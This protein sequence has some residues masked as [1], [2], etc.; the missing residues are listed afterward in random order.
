MPTDKEKEKRKKRAV[1]FAESPWIDKASGKRDD[2]FIQEAENLKHFYSKNQPDYDFEIVPFYGDINE[3]KSKLT[4]V[5]D[6]D[7]IYV[8]GHGAD[9]L[10]NIPNQ[11]IADVFKQQGV[12]N[13]SFGSCSFG[14]YIDP[15][16]DIQNVKYRD[17]DK[18]YGVWPN[19]KDV[20]SAMFA[21]GLDKEKSEPNFPVIGVS[22]PV[23]G[24]HFNRI[25]NRPK[26]EAIPVPPRP[27]P[28]FFK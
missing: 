17:E 28:A 19:A 7:Q 10:G 16:K 8:F 22:K 14:N 18:W 3:V 11:Q 21:K 23:Q 25:F 4:D 13:C 27:N 9:R 24:V 6:E 12:K 15:F 5:G 2:V 1:V 26:E 20:D